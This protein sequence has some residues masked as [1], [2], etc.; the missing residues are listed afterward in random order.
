VDAAS[1]VGAAL[2]PR[3]LTVQ[4]TPAIPVSGTLK[5]SEKLTQTEALS[6]VQH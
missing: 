1:P 6:N 2:L 4:P 5:K 3:N